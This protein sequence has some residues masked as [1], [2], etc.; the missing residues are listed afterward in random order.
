MNNTTQTREKKTK[1]QDKL[2][3]GN[4]RRKSKGLAV[5]L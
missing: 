5:E 4:G 3:D 2:K 1:K